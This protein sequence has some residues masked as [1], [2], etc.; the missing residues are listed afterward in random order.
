GSTFSPACE[1]SAT[2]ETKAVWPS[3]DIAIP[4]V[5]PGKGIVWT[6]V[7]ILPAARRLHFLEPFLFLDSAALFLPCLLPF[8]P[9]AATWTIRPS[10]FPRPVESAQ[11]K[12]PL[13]VRAPPVGRLPSGVSLP[14][15]SR[16]R[17]EGW[18]AV[19]GPITPTDPWPAA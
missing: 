15:G 19:E 3:G 16:C 8:P 14:A 18:M 17:P 9:D 12:R 7:P 1:E 2:P 4:P 5:R 10:F 11:R 6:T 13:V